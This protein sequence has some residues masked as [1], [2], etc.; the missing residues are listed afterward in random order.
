MPKTKRIPLR[1]IAEAIDE[2]F[3]GWTQFLN[4]KTGEIVSLSDPVVFPWED[5]EVELAKEIDESDDYVRLPD[6]HEIHEFQ[7]MEAF[8]A[9]ISNEYQS[10]RLY[11]ALN[12]RKPYHHFKDEVQYLGIDSQYYAF[13]FSEYLVLAKQWC[14]QHDVPYIEEISNT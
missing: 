11:R 1:T 5:D 12:G 7:I 2:A 14:E 13:R 9:S 8:A 6:Q 10:G 3:S 4:T